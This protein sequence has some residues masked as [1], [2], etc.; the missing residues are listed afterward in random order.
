MTG[1]QQS[2]VRSCSRADSL[3]LCVPLASP[4]FPPSTV[5][6]IVSQLVGHPEAQMEITVPSKAQWGLGPTFVGVHF[7]S[8]RRTGGQEEC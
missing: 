7:V 1:S 8:A 2:P 6:I 4:R 3:T 5:E